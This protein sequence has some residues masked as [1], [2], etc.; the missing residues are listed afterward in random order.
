[1]FGFGAEATG[2]TGSVGAEAGDTGLKG[3]RLG[4]DTPGGLD[5]YRFGISVAVSD[6]RL[7]RFSM[8]VVTGSPRSRMT[9]SCQPHELPFKVAEL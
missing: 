9:A 3:F 5:Q 1:M 6:Q 8:T 4:A 7:E 2:E